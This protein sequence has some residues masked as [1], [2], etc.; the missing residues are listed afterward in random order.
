MLQ[1]MLG[2]RRDAGRARARAWPAASSGRWP[3]AGLL[4]PRRGEGSYRFQLH[5]RGRRLPRA[6]HALSADAAGRGRARRARG[7][8]RGMTV[9]P[10]RSYG[11]AADQL[12]PD[13]DRARVRA[14]RH[15]L[16]AD[17]DGRDA[18]DLHRLGPGERPALAGRLGPRLGDRRVRDAARLDRRAQAARR[19]Q[20]PARRAHGRDPAPDRPLAA[21][22][23]RLRR[24]GRADRSTSTA[25]CSRPTAARAAP[26]S[27]AAWWRCGWPASG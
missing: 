17:L 15:R 3:P 8:G 25:T 9:A 20:G 24:A 27:P 13:D 26:R 14:H 10:E 11:R 4:N 7:E 19:H 16:G 12:R 2:P 23:G 5:R 18:G 22:R 21:R 1:R 6:R